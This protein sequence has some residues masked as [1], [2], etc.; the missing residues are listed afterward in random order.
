MESLLGT[1][2]FWSTASRRWTEKLTPRQL[3]DYVLRLLLPVIEQATQELLKVVKVLQ[4]R[5]IAVLT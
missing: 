1:A 5:Y 4:E 2:A 3:D